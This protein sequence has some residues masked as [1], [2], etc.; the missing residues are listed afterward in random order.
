ML[1]EIKEEFKGKF[2]QGSAEELACMEQDLLHYDQFGAKEAL[3]LGT[4]VIRQSERYKEDICFYIMRLS[5]N[6][7]IFQYIGDSCSQRNLSFAAGKFNTVLKT[8]HCSLWALAQE[9]TSGGVNAVFS[10]NSNCIPA[11]GA[12]PIFENNKMVAVLATSGLHD[13]NDHR[14]VVE[15]LCKIQEKEEPRFSGVII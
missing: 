3:Q 6:V 8:G 9:E 13:G 14:V 10:E 11:G 7:P 4:E 2:P 12:F 15:A 1:A 5:D